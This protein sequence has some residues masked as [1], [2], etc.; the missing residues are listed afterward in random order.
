MKN[1]GTVHPVASHTFR[2]IAHAHPSD[3]QSGNVLLLALKGKPWTSVP[4]KTDMSTGKKTS[5]Y[6]GYI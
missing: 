1:D 5:D 2:T 6:V 3:I 4:L